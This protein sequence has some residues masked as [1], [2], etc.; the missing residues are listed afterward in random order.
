MMEDCNPTGSSQQKIR[1]LHFA[2]NETVLQ[3]Q[4]VFLGQSFCKFVDWEMKCSNSAK[5]FCFINQN[6]PLCRNYYRGMACSH[7]FIYHFL[8][9]FSH[10]LIPNLRHNF[11]NGFRYRL[12]IRFCSFISVKM[13]VYW[14]CLAGRWIVIDTKQESVEV[15]LFQNPS[16][17]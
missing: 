12:Y 16:P 10:H 3:K 2:L 1:F 13:T 5:S 11:P 17:S 7:N 8:F 4:S 9:P 14:N 6:E 15:S